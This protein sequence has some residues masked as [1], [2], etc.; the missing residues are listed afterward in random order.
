MLVQHLNTI[1]WLIGIK[2]KI[3]QN[4]MLENNTKTLIKVHIEFKFCLKNSL[5]AFFYCKKK[6]KQPFM[7]IQH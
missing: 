2:L 3:V 7:V 1:N 5:A 6:S 4:K